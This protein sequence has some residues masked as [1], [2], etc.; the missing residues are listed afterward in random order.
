MWELLSPAG[1]MGRAEFWRKGILVPI[2]LGP[3]CVI[4]T[5]T[6]ATLLYELLGDNTSRGFRPYAVAGWVVSFFFIASALWVFSASFAKRFRDRGKGGQWV[7]LGLIP[8]FG[9]FWILIEC[10]MFP[11]E[12]REFSFARTAGKRMAGSVLILTPLAALLVFISETIFVYQLWSE[13]L[14]QYAWYAPLLSWGPVPFQYYLSPEQ[15]VGTD[16]LWL[17]AS[18]AAQ[19]AFGSLLGGYALLLAR[20]LRRRL[21]K[22]L[23]LLAP[24]FVLA[25][26]SFTIAGLCAILFATSID[27]DFERFVNAVEPGWRHEIGYHIHHRA[28]S[29]VELYYDTWRVAGALGFTLFGLGIAF[30][31]ASIWRAG[32]FVWVIPVAS[33]IISI[34]MFLVWPFVLWSPA[35][36]YAPGGFMWQLLDL[37]TAAYRT[38]TLFLSIWLSLV[39]ILLLSSRFRTQT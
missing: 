7:L 16:K 39:V 33:L 19:I 13:Y 27:A 8:P 15:Y 4:L 3:V 22:P 1:R 37:S 23:R 25:G 21:D 29:E 10:G 18:G 24:A 28:A 14:A 9:L 36:A 31:A 5:L 35:A 17:S 26:L 34:P 6:I 32:E 20:A 12:N 30:L 2:L 38:S 11:S